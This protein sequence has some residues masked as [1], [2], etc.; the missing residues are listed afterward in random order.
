MLAD[1]WGRSGYSWKP[2]DFIRYFQYKIGPY[3][4]D[5]Y[6][7][8][9]KEPFPLRYKNEVFNKLSEYAGYDIIKYLEFHYTAFP[10]HQDFLRFLNYELAERIKASSNKPRNLKFQSALNW[11][12][13]RRQE[14]QKIRENQLQQEVQLDVRNIIQNQPTASPEEIDSQ[15]KILSGKLSSHIESIMSETELGI[16]DLT[17]SY[18]T[19]KIELNNRNH[20]GKLVQLL[21]LLQLVKAP[22][23]KSNVDQLFKK[24]SRTDIASILHL[25]FAAFKVPKINTIQREVGDQ[26]DR[27]KSTNLKVKKLEDALQEFFYQ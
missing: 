24:F 1:I 7:Y 12:T 10:D 16:R 26:A 3:Q 2:G 9:P 18:V 13:E 22:P 17:G 23:Q 4:P 27:I 21:I 14:L 15:I 19:G 6:L 5:Q 20:E 8:F 11:V 25:H